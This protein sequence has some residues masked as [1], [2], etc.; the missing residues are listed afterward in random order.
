MYNF[1]EES[2][3][4]SEIAFQIR[5]ALNANQRL[6]GAVDKGDKIEI[7]GSIQSILVS[8]ANVS[9][10]LWPPPKSKYTNNG[11]ALRRVL[12]INDD[13]ILS[14]RDFRNTF[15]H[16][17]ERLLTWLEKNPLPFYHDLAMNPNLDELYDYPF[18]DITFKSN[19]HRGYNSFDNSLVVFGER[20]Y[21]NKLIQSLEELLKKC[22][23]YG[24]L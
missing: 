17:D 7:W 9:K 14:N 6:K 24:V 13:D 19:I 23:A 12:Q 5:I 18:R 3:L 16:Y 20:F 2:V 10:I 4:V 15:E 21:L 22:Q 8:S 1:I 11:A